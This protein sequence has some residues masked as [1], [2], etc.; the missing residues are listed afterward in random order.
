MAVGTIKFFNQAKGF[1]F[2]TPDNG[3]ADVFVH[4]STVQGSGSLRDGQT[5]SYQKR[6]TSG[7]CDSRLV[8]LLG[9]LDEGANPQSTRKKCPRLKKLG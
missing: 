5:V 1:G 8:R 3:G 6:K 7:Q 9:H 2:I 4:V